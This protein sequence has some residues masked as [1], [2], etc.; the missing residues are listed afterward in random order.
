MMVGPRPNIDD[1]IERIDYNKGYVPGNVKWASRQEQVL[2][3]SDNVVLEIDGVTKT[4]SQW[5]EESSVSGFTIYKRIK[6]GWLEKYG[7][8]KTVFEPSSRAGVQLEQE[9]SLLEQDSDS[10]SSSEESTSE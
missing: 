6:R 4:V 1:T 5:A 2:N 8:H 9:E 7:S 10:A 3:K